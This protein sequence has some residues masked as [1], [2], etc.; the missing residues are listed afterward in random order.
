MGFILRI[1]VRKRDAYCMVYDQ[2]NPQLKYPEIYF[3]SDIADVLHSYPPVLSKKPSAPIPPTPPKA[4]SPKETRMGIGPFLLYGIP[5]ASL[6]GFF[7]LRGNGAATVLG[8]IVFILFLFLPI[9]FVITAVIIS[10]KKS[11]N[12]KLTEYQK[13]IEHF[14]RMEKKYHED[15]VSLPTRLGQYERA[16][17]D[18]D[19]RTSLIQQYRSS[20]ISSRRNEFFEKSTKQTINK[21]P[22]EFGL[23]SRL[24]ELYPNACFDNA[25]VY[26]ESN[27]L[28]SC[29]YS[30]YPDIAIV[31]DGLYID[32]EIDEPYTIENGAA[33]PIHYLTG[34][35]YDFKSI[36]YERN[37][38]MSV[39]GWEIIRFSEEQVV[40]H[41]DECVQFVRAFIK[42]I[43][44][45]SINYH[46][47]SRGRLF[48]KDDLTDQEL[49]D[50]YPWRQNKWTKQEAIRLA[51]MGYRNSYLCRL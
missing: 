9:C 11:I 2:D 50:L 34:S 31:I 51:N 28:A 43:L 14:E 46:I 48:Y 47:D 5:A 33:K 16:L 29:Y 3:S 45:R 15:V 7:M 12:E 10:T 35:P 24:S 25:Q 17:K 27:S 39:S 22:A 26:L 4:L 32:I 20:Q 13:S 19:Y 38:A 36:D 21:G 37:R 18:S 49:D 40:L 30:Y 23:Y 41:L 44:E 8:S 1:F 42:S 6:I